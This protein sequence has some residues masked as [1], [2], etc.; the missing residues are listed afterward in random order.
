VDH[1]K[2]KYTKEHEWIYVNSANI[3]SV[4]I[5]DYAQTH[6]GD[7]VYIDLPSKGT[8]LEQFKKMGE[9]ESVKAV[10]EIF[11]PV[12]GQVA[13]LNQKSIDEPGLVNQSPYDEGWLVKIELKSPGELDNLMNNNQYEQFIEKLTEENPQ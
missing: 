1:Q 11:A 7:I 6:L 10:S 13:E 12:S 9:I 5:T 3:A 2:Y 4:G 8:Q